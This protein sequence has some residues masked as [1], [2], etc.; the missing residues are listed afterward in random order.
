MNRIYFVFLLFLLPNGSFGQ[1]EK[2]FIETYYISDEIDSTDLTGGK[3]DSGSVTY[4]VYLD[5]KPGSVLKRIYGGENHP[6]SFSSTEVFFN[7]VDGQT[8][9]KDFLK[10]RYSENTI[11]LDTWI[12][13]GQ[14][15][16]VQ[17]NK[18]YFGIPKNQD[19]DGSFIGGINND[20]GS[21]VIAEGLLTNDD[22]AMNEQLT[23]ADGMDT[24]MQFPSSW[25]DFGFKDVASGNDSTVLGS[26][27]EGT[28][29]TS[30]NCWL[31]N[32][33][34]KGVVADSNQLLIAQFTT[35]GELSFAFNLE[36]E[37]LVDT[38]LTTVNY[39]A[40]NTVLNDGEEFSPYL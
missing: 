32:S 10:S 35:K 22:P 30:T 39:V 18:A 21:E 36:V 24:L 38:V 19:T 8:F 1:L 6:L 2:V 23:I 20:G 5:L 7:N 4:R 15:T 31:E 12:T 33:G 26:L 3:L 40:D 11:A 17:G 27:V 16:K 9:G 14:T 34:S 29:F 13:L 28:S 25:T 37:Y